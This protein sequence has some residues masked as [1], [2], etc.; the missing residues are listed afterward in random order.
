M[1]YQ[2]KVAKGEDPSV[3]KLYGER[4]VA[5][6]CQYFIKYVTKTSNILDVG[7]GPGVITADLAKIAS[8]GK[9]IGIDNSGGIIAEASTSFPPSAVPNLTF[10]VGDAMKLDFPDNTFDVVHAHALFVH[11]PD[12]ITALKE[13]YRVCKP[14]GIIVCREATPNKIFSLVPDL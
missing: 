1:A 4:T 6:S 14:G 8:E 13:F 3:T 2:A 9:T 11:I 5:T 10:T 7:C 12:T